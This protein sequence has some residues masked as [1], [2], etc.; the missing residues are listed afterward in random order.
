MF[1]KLSILTILLIAITLFWGCLG[2]IGNSGRDFDSSVRNKITVGITQRKDILPFLGDPESKK[3]L[4]IGRKSHEEYLYKYWKDESPLIQTEYDI[5][6]LHGKLLTIEFI[7]ST[8]NGFSFTSLFDKDSTTFDIR[9]VNSIVTDQ[10]SEATVIKLIGKPHGKILLPSS[11]VSANVD[12]P[13]GATY[14]FMYHTSSMNKQT[15]KRELQSA[16][17]F[18]DANG[19]V[20]KLIVRNK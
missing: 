17:L 6:Y 8:V 19:I 12:V 1:S 16:F 7:D 18:F 15:N 4:T 13:V 3:L 11:F 9:A 5:S 14:A 10:T 2:G 20:R